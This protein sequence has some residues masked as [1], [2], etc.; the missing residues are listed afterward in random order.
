MIKQ[1]TASVYIIKNQKALLIFHPKLHKWLPPGGH[2]EPNEMPTETAKREA[3]E[4]TGLDIEFIAQENIWVNYWNAR[5]FERPY[6]CLLEEIPAYKDQAA[7]QH[8]DFVYLARP[9]SQQ[10]AI[11]TTPLPCQWFDRTDLGKLQPDVDIF[12]ETLDVLNHLLTPSSSINQP[13]SE[14]IFAE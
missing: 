2:V 4:E 14:L 9:A 12:K 10:S 7:H 5:S 1:F 13:A 3:K 6:L 11:T 8:I